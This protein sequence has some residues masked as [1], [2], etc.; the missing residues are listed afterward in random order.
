MK[1]YWGFATVGS[2][3]ILS[4]VLGFIRDVLIAA[5]LGTSF[6]AD[7]FFV[8]FRLPNVFGRLQEAL[9][10]A[11]IPLF[12][13]RLHDEGPGAARTFAGKTLTNLSLVLLALTIVGEI[14]MPW[15]MLVLGPGFASDP[16]KFDLAVMLARIALPYL[17][18]T[19]LIAL[20]AGVLNAFGRFGI[21]ALAPAL[22]NAVFIAVLLVLV[23]LDSGQNA[24][25]VALAW[26][27][28]GAGV[29]QVLFLAFACAKIGMNVAWQLPGFTTDMRKLATLA[30]PGI[31]AS[32]MAQLTGVISMI[33]ATL[34]D[35]VVS[36]LYYAQRIFQLPLGV[37]GVTI[38]VVLLPHLSHDLRSGDHDSVRASENRALEFALLLT[39]PAAVAL[40]VAAEPILR[41]LF[42]RGA[43]THTDTDA[44]AAM[45]SA[46]APGL[47]AYVLIK[48]LHPS[49]FAREDTKTPMA[50]A[51]ISMVANAVL[52]FTLFMILGATGIAVATTLSGWFN[53]TL[54]LNTLM[55][56]DSFRPDPAFLRRLVGM[57]GAS[58]TMGVVVYALIQ[59]LAPWFA[60]INSF[61]IQALALSAVVGA[62]LLVYLS[63]IELFGTAKLRDLMR[64]LTSL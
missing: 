36:W 23:V 34:Q 37:I 22:F 38:A 15:F 28:A 45:L 57:A 64:D 35:S 54:L 20:Y 42:E 27:I 46:L 47:P 43:F 10:A 24:A 18:C 58:V 63:G 11:F 61:P 49:F 56:R 53:V 44:T 31:I 48:V 29:L 1:L 7:A 25:G 59:V 32:G 51:G 8:A 30:T 16:T 26:G 5:V 17:I 21:A 3:T 50:L 12:T 60:P 39:L 19:S 62:G 40:L 13:K 2:I 55:R 9:D 4:R 33:I 41:V 14:A 52:S 6:V